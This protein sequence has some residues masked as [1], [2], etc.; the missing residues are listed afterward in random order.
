[1]SY[2]YRLDKQLNSLIVGATLC[3]SAVCMTRVSY[4]SH[5]SAR[6][7]VSGHWLSRSVLSGYPYLVSG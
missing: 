4:M 6:G 2:C 7:L 3:G 5:A 1:M